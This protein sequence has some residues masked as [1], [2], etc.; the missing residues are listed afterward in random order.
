MAKGIS[1]LHI[2]AAALFIFA[3]LSFPANADHLANCV[4]GQWIPPEEDSRL[5]VYDC[6]DNRICG[7]IIWLREPNQEDGTPKVDTL[8]LNE[9]ERGRPVLGMIFLSDFV[10]DSNKHNRWKSGKIYNPRNGRLYK[11]TMTIKGDVLKV[12]GYVGVPLIGE[13][14]VWTRVPAE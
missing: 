1:I 10:L 14:Q 3:V 4:K 5:E 9:A 6:G 2:T 12:R 11:A 8:N 13:T 7:R